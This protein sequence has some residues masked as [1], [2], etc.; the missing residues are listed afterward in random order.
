MKFAGRL[1]PVVV[2][3]LV[4]PTA[5]RADTTVRAAQQKLQEM[6]LYAG[7]VDGIAGSQTA[8][9]LRRY[10]LREGLK[11]TGRLNRETLESLGIPPQTG[12]PGTRPPSE[13]EIR[14]AELFSG[15]ALSTRPESEQ[16]RA[17]RR[18]QQR[19]KSLG[20]FSAE[21]DGRATGTFQSALIE[22]QK[23]NG[24]RPTGRF[25]QSTREQLFP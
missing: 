9:A 8:A 11:V 17:L 15:T 24:L 12:S 10:Q 13:E 3:L 14:L 22:W 2:L 20:Y 4:W 21:P 1:L 23:A 6:G 16:R 19:L 5:A 25:D 7:A 18:V